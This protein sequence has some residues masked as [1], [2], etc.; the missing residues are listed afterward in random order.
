MATFA[1]AKPGSGKNFAK[2]SSTLA[3]RGAKNPDALAAYIGRRKYGRKRFGRM[4]AGHSHSNVYGLAAVPDALHTVTHEHGSYGTHTHSFADD[5]GDNYG[6]DNSTDSGARATGTSVQRQPEALRTP[7]PGTGYV[8]SGAPLTVRSGP[9][10]AGLANTGQRDIR[11]SRRMQVTGPSD[12]IVSRSPDGAAVIR[13]RLGGASIGTIRRTTDGAWV[14]QI[15][16]EQGTL[17]ERTH[18][19]TAL[20]DLLGTW[21]KTA[22]S[23]FRPAAPALQP[24]PQQTPLMAQYGIPAVRALATPATGAGAGP[25]VTGMAGTAGDGDSDDSGLSSK[26]QAIYRKLKARGFPDARAMAFARRAQNMSGKA[27]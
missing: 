26:G 24:P 27:G 16:G 10:G 1:G 9:G 13:H 8:R 15:D 2:L 18:Q 12:I 6:R 5:H 19:R 21:N 22:A 3:A 23:P 17:P 20:A 11:L 25:R 4:S 14:S 7:A